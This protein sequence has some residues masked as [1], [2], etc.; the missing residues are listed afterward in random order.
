MRDNL[1][2]IDHIPA[3]GQHQPEGDQ[4]EGDE[5]RMIGHQY[6]PQV[7]EVLGRQGRGPLFMW[8]LLSARRQMQK[9]NSALPEL[10]WSSLRH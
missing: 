6:S 3:S 1:G 4:G 5:A 8:A 9:Y 2:V 7:R 10:N